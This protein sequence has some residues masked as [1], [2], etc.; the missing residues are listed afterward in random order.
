MTSV[1]LKNQIENIIRIKKTNVI[2]SA[3]MNNKEEILNMCTLLGSKL[4]GVKIHSDIINDFDQNF[5]DALVNLSNT[6]SFIIIDDRK[7]CDIGNTVYQQSQSITKYADLITVHGLPGPGII[8]GLRPNCV[9][10]VCGILLIAEM[11]SKDNLLNE[12]YTRSV[13]DMAL[14]N[15]DIVVGFISQ[16]HLCCSFLHFSPGV[17]L[18]IQGDEMGQQYRT[19][20]QKIDEDNVDI[21]IVGRGL[22]NAASPLTE[23]T[24][25]IYT[26]DDSI[27]KDMKE[28]GIVKNGLFTLKCGKKTNTYVDCRLLMQKPTVM[29]RI[30][31]E[32][33]VLIKKKLIEIGYTTEEEIQNDSCNYVIAGVPMGALPLATIVSQVSN[34]P[35]IMIRDKPKEYG[36]GSLIEGVVEIPTKE[37]P[38]DCVLIED[39]LTTGIS[40]INTIHK[41]RENN[42][43]VI[44]V[45]A[46]VDREMG[47][48]DAIASPNLNSSDMCPSIIATATLFKISDLQ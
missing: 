48:I 15:E 27:I 38:V 46:I 2:F 17:A 39:V 40:V 23:I 3:D 30:A 12:E 9:K 37:Q 42:Y 11:S 22:I 29:Y 4:L 21:L 25:Y 24:K 31:Y 5:I 45:A 28:L 14:D 44:F 10:N 13:V 19:P 8:E 43:N 1:Y 36:T 34:Y 18:Y 7:F 41:L 32:L 35:M 47:A 6:E 20:Q 26:Q 16:R 33:N